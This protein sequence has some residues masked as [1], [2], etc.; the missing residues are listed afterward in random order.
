MAPRG[1]EERD[2]R[3]GVGRDR[4][5]SGVCVCTRWLVPAR[6][7]M[8]TLRVSQLPVHV[9]SNK[10]M[11][12]SS[13]CVLLCYLPGCVYRCLSNSCVSFLTTV[14]WSRLLAQFIYMGLC[15]CV[16]PGCLCVSFVM[17][18]GEKCVYL[19]LLCVCVSDVCVS[20]FSGTM[21]A[22]LLGEWL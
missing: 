9:P 11:Y 7:C 1:E 21:F 16:F 10:H 18:V 20:F 8:N 12:V 13:T 22:S 14:C 5:W 6:L 19:S 2:E 17:L 3:H 15:V 4:R